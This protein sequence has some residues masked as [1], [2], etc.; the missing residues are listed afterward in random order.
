MNMSQTTISTLTLPTFNKSEIKRPK[1]Q[2]SPEVEFNY[3]SP[4]AAILLVDLS[5][6]PTPVKAQPPITYPPPNNQP[7]KP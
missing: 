2:P 4:T 7:Q 6:H 5:V 3:K 1:L